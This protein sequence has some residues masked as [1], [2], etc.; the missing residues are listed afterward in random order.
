MESG[1]DCMY[2]TCLRKGEGHIC[3][4]C[5]AMFELTLLIMALTVSRVKVLRKAVPNTLV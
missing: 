4:C 3:Q 1:N 5:E 2:R